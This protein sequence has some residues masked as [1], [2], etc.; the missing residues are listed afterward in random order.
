MI[1]MVRLIVLMVWPLAVIFGFCEYGEMLS[2]QF[3]AVGDK[4]CQCDWYTFPIKLQRIFL[5]VVV[6][7]QQM[8]VIYCF[9]NTPC[10]RDTFKKVNLTIYLEKKKKKI[11][12]WLSLKTI[13]F[14][15]FQTIQASFSYFMAISRLAG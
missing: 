13:L 14:F 5:I 4:L 8:T 9:E 3:D 15:F 10:A 6:N 12:Q 2:E 1:E 7:A 11:H